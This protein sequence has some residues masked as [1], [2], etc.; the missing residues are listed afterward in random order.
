MTLRWLPGFTTW[1]PT[2]LGSALALWLDADDA[3]T[4]IL[5]GSTVSQWRD[6]S[7][8]ARHASQATAANQPTYSATGL[9][10]KGT[11]NFDGTND[12][13]TIIGGNI[14]LHTALSG[15]NN[16]SATMLIFPEMTSNLPV[17]FH[18]PL[19][20]G[21]YLFLFE[22]NNPGLYW[23]YSSTG[24]QRVYNSGF[25]VNTPSF[26]TAN[27]TNATTGDL[28]L[29]GAIQSSFTGALGATPTISSAFLL[30]SYST[31]S[32]NYKG[33]FGEIIFTEFSL[34][35]TDRERLEGYLAWKWGTVASLPAGHPY[36]NSP[37]Y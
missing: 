25:T 17:L 33:K 4:I 35:T 26:F 30:G 23:I 19:G 36:K 9:N 3:S 28:Y 31:P 8:N 20:G 13:M 2:E 11:L 21:G 16:H 6:K 15:D 12:S 7:G 37:P 34:S 24:P 27:K 29:N 10:G 1:T 22:L 18:S 32:F 14:P 5:N